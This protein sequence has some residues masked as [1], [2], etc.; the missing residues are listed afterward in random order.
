M[1][2]L[3]TNF[4]KNCH[5]YTRIFFIFLES[6]LNQTENA[7]NNK[8]LGQRKDQKSSYQVREAFAI[9]FNMTGLTLS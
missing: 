2:L 6:V 3:T 7:F 9:S 8:Y 1:F 4:V 5:I